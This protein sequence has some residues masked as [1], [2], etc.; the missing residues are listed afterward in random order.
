MYRSG[1][2]ML[3]LVLLGIC[4]PVGAQPN[5]CGSGWNTNLVPDKIYLLQCTMK[6]ACDAHDTCYGVCENRTDGECVYRR[7]R[8]GGDMEG[9][10]ACRVDLKFLKSESDAASRRSVCDAKFS[11]AIVE[12][13]PERW[14]CKAVAIIYREAVKRWGDSSFSGYGSWDQPAAWSQSQLDYEQAIANFI[15]SSSEE[16]FMR[17]VKSFES[18]T[19]EVNFCGRLQYVNGAGLKNIDSTEKNICSPALKSGVE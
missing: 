15:A 9:A 8:A 5:G 12:S 16:S 7:C 17:F 10:P 14:A 11:V 4:T 19:P 6:N 1:C 18:G 13:N 2:V 3:L